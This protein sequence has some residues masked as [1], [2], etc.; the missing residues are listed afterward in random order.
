MTKYNKLLFTL[1]I[2]VFL[3]S[4]SVNVYGETAVE[5]TVSVENTE[6]T[7]EEILIRFFHNTACGTCDGTEEF[8]AI[9][10]EQISYYKEQYPYKLEMYNV[11]KTTGEAEWEKTA[12]TYGLENEEYIYPSVVINGEMYRGIDEI[13]ENF[14]EMFLRAAGVSALYFYRQDCQE[15]IDMEPFWTGLPEEYT[16]EEN[17]FI[18]EIAELETRTENNGDQIRRLFKEY[19]VTDEDQ[20][21]PCVFLSDSYLAGHED[22]EEKLLSLLEEGKGFQIKTE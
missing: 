11:F 6:E 22:I 10:E 7:A 9:V 3:A 5:E 17:V 20:M 12:E 18:C 4:A 14:H 21:V 19:E 13:K 1:G 15:C 2:S 16:V 8:L